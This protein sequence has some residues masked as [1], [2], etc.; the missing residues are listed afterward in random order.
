MAQGP[1]ALPVSLLAPPAP[2]PTLQCC[3]WP[4]ARDTQGAHGRGSAIS[5]ELLASCCLA[6]RLLHCCY[7]MP[8]ALREK[9]K[10]K[11]REGNHK[12]DRG[13]QQQEQ[14]ACRGN[15]CRRFPWDAPSWFPGTLL[16]PPGPFTVLKLGA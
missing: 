7:L 15:V 9:K 4:G 2:P 14:C 13:K 8:Q 11:E 16:M 1:K 6:Q 10:K 5:G 3:G 12:G